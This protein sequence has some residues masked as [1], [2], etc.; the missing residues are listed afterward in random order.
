MHPLTVL[1]TCKKYI[2]LYRIP[3]Y[4]GRKNSQNKYFYENIIYSL[5]YALERKTG[6]VDEKKI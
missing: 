5:A 2:I 6:R 1:I 3:K 4:I